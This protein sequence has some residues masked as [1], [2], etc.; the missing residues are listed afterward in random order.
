[1]SKFEFRHLQYRLGTEQVQERLGIEET[2]EIR[3]NH[4]QRKNFSKVNSRIQAW[5]IQFALKFTGLYGKGLNNA[6]CVEVRH[7]IV[8]SPIIPQNFSGLSILHLSDLHVDISQSAMAVVRK[9]LPSLTYDLCV[10]TGD[11]RGL[12]FGPIEDTLK[13]LSEIVRLIDAP[14]Y[15]V[16]GNHDSIHMLEGLEDLGIR[17]LMNE[18]EIIESNKER[19][20]LAGIDD[21]H[22][23]RTHDVKKVAI[24]IPKNEFSVLLSHTPE[25]YKQA[26]Q[27]EFNLMLSGHTHGGQICLPG[28][29]PLTL[30]SRQLPRRFGSGNWKYQNLQGYTSVGAGTSVV[31]VRFNC[32]PEITLHYLEKE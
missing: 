4:Q 1:M 26:A 2:H 6:T 5:G 8:R 15:G 30:S 22:Y 19:I 9:V 31:P 3:K 28:R 32:T 17:M 21:A 23:Y 11:Y 29:L 27:A 24:E 20:F 16:L 12:T 25:V 10:L 7:N 18:T 14:I 13:G